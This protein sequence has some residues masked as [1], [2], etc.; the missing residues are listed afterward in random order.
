MLRTALGALA[1]TLAGL[2]MAV[3]ILGVA[4][5]VNTWRTAPRVFEM[6]HWAI[7]LSLILGAGFGAVCG[8]LAGLASAVLR[9][10]R[11]RPT[12]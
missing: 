10:W 4:W 7:Y 8:A 1:G 5:W 11:E 12:G 2:G 3:L 6:E 9:T